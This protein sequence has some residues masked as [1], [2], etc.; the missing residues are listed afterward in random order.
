M[1]SVAPGWLSEQAALICEQATE[2]AKRLGVSVSCDLNFRK[3]LWS[4]E[5]AGQVMGKLMR[6]VDLVIANEEDADKVFGIKAAASDVT[7]GHLSDEGYQD[8]ARQLV[9]RFG[10]KKV[11]ITLRE[12]FSASENGWSGMYYDGEGFYKSKRYQLHL[13][14][15]VGGGD[16]FGAGLIYAICHDMA[17]QDVIN[18]AAAA[19]A[20]AHTIEGDMNLTT[21]D[22]VKNLMG[23]DGSGRVQR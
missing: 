21:L 2:A 20:L 15:R 10:V 18:F 12:S 7:G 19:S 13:V 8:V 17:P 16:S 1:P 4:S 23:G 11:A 5:R 6:N 3:N 22:E 9:A 14:D